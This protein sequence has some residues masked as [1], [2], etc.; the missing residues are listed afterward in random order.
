MYD[1]KIVVYML[2]T[3]GIIRKGFLIRTFFYYFIIITLGSSITN[4]VSTLLYNKP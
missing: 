3:V 2:F 4:I 1:V